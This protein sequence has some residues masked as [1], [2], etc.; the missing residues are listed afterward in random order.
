MR[1]QPP[2][3]LR[4]SP[5][6]SHTPLVVPHPAVGESRTYTA[7]NSWCNLSSGICSSPSDEGTFAGHERYKRIE[8]TD[9]PFGSGFEALVVETDA[10]IVFVEN[11]K[12]VAWDGLT[13]THFLV[14]GLGTIRSE[15]LGGGGRP[16]SSVIELIDTSRN[17]VPEPTSTLLHAA[18]LATLL[19]LGR[20]AAR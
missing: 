16:D 20:R 7:T 1:A 8:I 3:D 9:V 10:A 19:G 4:S 12:D 15:T 18:A 13:R 2:F 17:V 11:G 6:R 5:S 14:P